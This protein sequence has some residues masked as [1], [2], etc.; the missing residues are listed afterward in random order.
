MENPIRSR[1]RVR[2]L[3]RR[4]L[5]SL[6]GIGQAGIGHIERADTKPTE[7]TLNRLAEIFDVP[8]VALEGELETYRQTIRAIA[9]QKLAGVT[10]SG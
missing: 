1:R 10:V 3:S 7:P 8:A 2:G 9:E 6:V 4:E 5:G